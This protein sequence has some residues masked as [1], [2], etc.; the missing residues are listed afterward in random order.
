MGD[1]A[2]GAVIFKKKCAQCH[3]TVEGAGNK[4]G[5]NLFG[6]V[7]RHSGSVEGFSYS[8]A[9]KNSGITWHR[10]N[11]LEYLINP[12]K[13]IK[14]TKMVFAGL[15]KEQDRLDLVSFLETQA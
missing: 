9:N 11:L 6:I 4:Q 3:T 5:P 15:K 12:K 14:G 2:K 7:G 1:A 13:Y 10:E 8:N